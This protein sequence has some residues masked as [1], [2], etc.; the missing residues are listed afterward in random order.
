ML[1]DAL[2]TFS[3]HLAVFW[4]IYGKHL[5]SSNPGPQLPEG[6][7]PNSHSGHWTRPR[8]QNLSATWIIQST[9]VS[10]A[11][12]Y[13][14]SRLFDTIKVS[15]HFIS[16]LRKLQAKNFIQTLPLHS[17]IA[18][19]VWP[20]FSIPT[21]RRI[22]SYWSTLTIVIGR[23]A[24]KSFKTAQT[25]QWTRTERVFKLSRTNIISKCIAFGRLPI[26]AI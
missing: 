11:S 3:R 26:L 1:L 14:E 18:H 15:N 23:C 20:S 10:R 12:E 4:S 24:P 2:G 17:N 16:R 7:R 25:L 5:L 6:A 21:F 9:N 19:I 22:K 8:W 13:L